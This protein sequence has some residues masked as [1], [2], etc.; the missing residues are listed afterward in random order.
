M[1][2]FMEKKFNT[3]KRTLKI[4]ETLQLEAKYYILVVKSTS[5]QSKN[6]KKKLR[7]NIERAGTTSHMPGSSSRKSY[8]LKFQAHHHL[9]GRVHYLTFAI[10]S[11]LGVK[12]SYADAGAK[13]T[14]SSTIDVEADI[15]A[16]R[17]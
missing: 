4:L 12:C 14:D 2:Y 15:K 6:L 9:L 1:H 13:D 3:F 11:K 8:E 5:A 17:V 7:I 10:F 16:E